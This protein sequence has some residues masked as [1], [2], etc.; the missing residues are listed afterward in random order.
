MEELQL[1]KEADL[2]GEAINPIPYSKRTVNPATLSAIWFGMAVQL[3]IFMASGLM[4]PS[5]SVKNIFIALVLANTLVTAI[6]FFTQDIGIKYGIPF[7]V[8]TRASFGYLGTHLPAVLRAVPAV[9]WFGFQTWIGSMALDELSKLIFGWSNLT[10]YI[11]FFGVLQILT[12]F[13]GIKFI[14]LLNWIG[15]P[16]LLLIGIYIIF[17][18]L[19]ANNVSL[20][21]VMSMGGEGGG[22]SLPLAVMALLGGWATLAVSI[23][24]IVRNC[25]YSEKD[26]QSTYLKANGKWFAAQWIGCVPAGVLFGTIGAMSMALT[27]EW[28]PVAVIANLPVPKTAIIVAQ[29]FVF[30]ATWTTN[31]AA[32]LLNPSYTL[33]NL[34]NGKIDYFKSVI[35]VGSLGLI[36]QPWKVSG[37]LL[38]IMGF[39]S[40]AL[41]PVAGILICDY[42]VLRNRNLNINALYNSHAY[43]KYANGINPAAIIAYIIGVICSIPFWNYVY[44]VGIVTGFI[45]YYILMKFWIVKSYHQP[46][47]TGS[48]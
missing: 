37:N 13:Y 29:F 25:H 31:P 48:K 27:G 46:D 21:Q 30:L 20:S 8:S 1:N 43:Y 18:L 34:L 5:L 15:S 19:K 40:A 38:N 44:I 23:Q 42:F 47:I 35:V 24:D 6:I 33:C 45:S 10:F 16:V 14:S 2:G 22:I 26:A 12:T 11:I 9:F 41:A 3:A 7:T 17:L 36:A 28:N 39:I 32:N 4:Y